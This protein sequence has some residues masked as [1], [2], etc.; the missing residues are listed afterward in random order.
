MEKEQIK[1]FQKE[2]WVFYHMYEGYT[3]DC[4]IHFRSPKMKSMEILKFSSQHSHDE[5]WDR[6]TEEDLR[7]A[8]LKALA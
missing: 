7:I 5:M 6:V 4:E 2:G 1:Q 3:K 8:E